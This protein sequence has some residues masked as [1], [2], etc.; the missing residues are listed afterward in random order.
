MS[1]GLELIGKFKTGNASG[2]AYVELPPIPEAA[3]EAQPLEV[4]QAAGPS[5]V[6]NAYHAEVIRKYIYKR[7]TLLSTGLKIAGIE[8]MRQLREIIEWP[9]ELTAEYPIA[10]WANVSS[11]TLTWSQVDLLLQKAMIQFTMQDESKLAGGRQRQTILRRAA[12]A[13]ATVI[14]NNILTTLF[15]GVYQTGKDVGTNDKWDNSGT[16]AP[17]IPGDFADAMG[18]LLTDAEKA[19]GELMTGMFALCPIKSIGYLKM[20]DVIN[21]IKMTTQDWLREQWNLDILFTRNSTYANDVVVGYKGQD[22]II[23]GVLT[24]PP[25]PL[26]EVRREH[27]VG[28]TYIIRRYFA[29]KILPYEMGQTTSKNLVSI[30][31][32]FS[33]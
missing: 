17:D 15:N 32:I 8:P 19:E 21:M 11:Q 27:G 18:L 3:Y 6:D 23:H 14:D 10:M 5:S 31:D 29:T 9:S 25:F 26:S 33:D 2:R 16:N 13:F 28:D 24:A 22:T 1:S 7:S 12:E 4:H 30:T 20:P